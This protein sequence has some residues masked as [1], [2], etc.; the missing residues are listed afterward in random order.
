MPVTTRRGYY[1]SSSVP[2]PTSIDAT[3]IRIK[4]MS[5]GIFEVFG[6]NKKVYRDRWED[7]L[8]DIKFLNDKE[9]DE[10]E[11]Y[12]EDKKNQPKKQKGNNVKNAIKKGTTK[13]ELALINEINDQ[14]DQIKNLKTLL[15]KENFEKEPYVL[16]LY[17]FWDSLEEKEATVDKLKKEMLEFVNHAAKHMS[18]KKCQCGHADNFRKLLEK[19]PFLNVEDLL[20]EE[21]IG[22]EKNP[23]IEINAKTKIISKEKGDLMK[24]IIDQRGKGVLKK[25]KV[26][27]Q[28]RKLKDKIMMSGKVTAKLC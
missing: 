6:R 10:K 22:K 15:N 24:Q 28:L 13:R 4:N 18:C 3:D 5:N 2:A 17:Q 23:K 1:T 25:I 12:Y 26:T 7:N 21:K 9:F 27:I 11:K 19:T 20:S 8:N 14:N 16:A